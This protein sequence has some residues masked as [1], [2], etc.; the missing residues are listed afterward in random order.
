M[1]QGRIVVLRGCAI[2][3]SSSQTLRFQSGVISPPSTIKYPAHLW[4]CHTT[5][6]VHFSLFFPKHKSVLLYL[7]IDFYIKNILLTKKKTSL[8]RIRYPL[9]TCFFSD[10]IKK[11]SDNVL[12]GRFLMNFGL[13][14]VCYGRK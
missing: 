3:P 12:A 8:Q 10:R 4:F 11:N 5:S 6:W 1:I 2:F 14:L 9:Q 7:K 13:N